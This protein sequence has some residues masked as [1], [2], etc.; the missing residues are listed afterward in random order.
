MR[1]YR[2]LAA[3]L[4]AA[5][6]LCLAT[7]ARA[8]AASCGEVPAAADGWKTAAPDSVGLNVRLLC[9][10]AESRVAG[11]RDNTHAVLVVRHGTLVFERYFA[12]EDESWGNPLGQVSYDRTKPHDI[13]SISKSITSLLVGIALD[14][15]KITSLDQP[16][17]DFFPEYIDL[18]TPEKQRIQLR[19]LLTMTSGLAWDESIPYSNPENSEIRMTF[20]PDP[21]RYV[22]EQVVATP[23][24]VKFNYSGG[25]TALLAAVV[26]KV[27]GQSIDQFA[28]AAL[29]ESLGITEFEWAKMPNG[30]PSAASGLRLRPRDLAKIG[31]LVLA[32]GVWNGRRL[33]SA[34]YI[35]EATKPH[36][37]APYFFY[38]YQWLLHRSLVGGRVVEWI[39]GYG[40]GGQRLFIVPSFDLV[41]V[42]TAGLYASGRQDIPPLEVLNDYVLPAIRGN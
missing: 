12:G 38:G 26:Q 14:Q 36:A 30:D 13:R 24:G 16:V 8:S 33:V 7:Y 41:V 40:L 34:A 25:S 11:P 42:V 9:Q 28:R 2:N 23:P 3:A 37:A 31:Q 10:W 1:V 19:H 21:Y 6:V 22:L 29:F 35:D 20:A 39:A 4:V 18:R 27:T 17:L 5:V 15:K 32:R